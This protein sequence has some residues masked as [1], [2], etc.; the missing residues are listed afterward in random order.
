MKQKKQVSLSSCIVAVLA[1]ALVGAWLTSVF[2]A[3]RGILPIVDEANQVI[4]ERFVG[5]YDEEHV[6]AGAVAGMVSGLQDRWSYYLT[7]EDYDAYVE[8]VNNEYVGIGVTIEA[9]EEKRL[10][11][12]SVQSGSS[13]QDAGLQPG[14]WIVAVEGE[15]FDHLTAQ[16]AKDRISGEEGTMVTL[17][18]LRSDGQQRDVTLTRKRVVIVPVESKML[19]GQVGYIRIFNFDNT[20]SQYAMEAVSEL[21]DQSAKRLLF[22]LRGNPGGLLDE[23]L[24]LLDFLMPEGDLFVSEEYTGKTTVFQ[25]DAACVDLPVTVLVNAETYSAA[26]FFAAVFQESGRGKVVGVQTYG[27]GYSQVPIR[28]SDGSAIVLS[29]AKYYT[30]KRVS[31]I[32]TGVVPDVVCT[33]TKEQDAALQSGTLAMEDDPQLQA[34][35]QDG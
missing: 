5:E 30:P 26:E 34:A 25:S 3:N 13:A 24:E 20:A 9:E 35:L 10:R 1:A 29:T 8:A 23:L 12:I 15:S 32:G 2:Q 31:L 14:E 6:R 17:T 28:L 18:I 33:M 19:E 16:Q 7:A 22:D 27:K 4:Q 21:M 11:I